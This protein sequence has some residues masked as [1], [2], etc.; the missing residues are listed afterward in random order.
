MVRIL[1]DNYTATPK[2]GVAAEAAEKA[3]LEM[4]CAGVGIAFA[5]T[6]ML[7]WFIKFWTRERH[8]T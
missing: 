8:R 6:C 3:K 5:I 7:A 1:L 2:G 4:W